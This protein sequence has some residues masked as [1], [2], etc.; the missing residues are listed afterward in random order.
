VLSRIYSAIVPLNVQGAYESAKRSLDNAISRNP[1]SPYL[2]LEKARLEVANNDTSEARVIVS[3]AL[4]M[5]NNY[6]DASFFLA[7]LEIN[8]GNV[9]KAIESLEQ[10]TL[11]SPNDAGLF[12]RLGL[13]KYNNKDYNGAIS[14]FGRA[15]TLV[16]D[17]ANA[18]YFL[19]LSYYNIGKSESAIEQFVEIE[20][21]NVGNS[22]VQ[23]ILSNLRNNRDPFSDIVPPVIPP[24]KR[25]GLPIDE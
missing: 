25:S 16:P 2:I 9:G 21:T 24:E 4:E 19:G 3:R 13:L 7:Q 12:F 20:K 1:Q 18:R 10:T 15:I 22:E 17:Y 5:K 11:I 23:R 8:E 14:A 6:T